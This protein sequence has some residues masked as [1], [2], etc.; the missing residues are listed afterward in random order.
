M[1]FKRINLW[2][3]AKQLR[4]LNS[5]IPAASEFTLN[6]KNIFIFPTSFGFLYLL[7]CLCLF[8]LG[9]NYQNN[10]MLL[11]CYFL[12][13]LFL[14]CLFACY[15]NVRGLKVKSDKPMTGF[16]GQKIYQ[17]IYLQRQLAPL[18]KFHIRYWQQPECLSQEYTQDNHF[19]PGIKFD[20][21]GAYHLPRVTLCNFYPLGLFR[22]WSH[23]A[24][25]QQAV[26]YPQATPSVL[27]VNHTQSHQ[28]DSGT[29]SG[30]NND[31]DEYYSLEKHQP[32]QP[33]YHVDWKQM[34]KGRGMLTKHFVSNQK[35]ALWLSL[36]PALGSNLEIQLQKLCFLVLELSQQNQ[37][38]GLDL[39][40]SKLE[41]GS[42]QQHREQCLKALAIYPGKLWDNND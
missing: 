14:V 39:G 17:S 36:S 3:Q 15:I 2:Q 24:F 8:L 26:I 38:F 12:L 10:L 29:H 6:H 41:L 9:S 16:A 23:L 37:E 25:V 40:H 11:L 31:T 42:G 33:L 28:N 4:W 22:C 27:P 32:G 30:H 21:R 35:G 18:G 19:Q 7:L 34:A 20:T 1:I 5:R 13:A